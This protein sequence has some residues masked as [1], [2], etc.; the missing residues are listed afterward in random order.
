[1]FGELDW[2]IEFG[3]GVGLGFG[4]DAVKLVDQMG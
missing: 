3:F 1:M 4:C 2:G